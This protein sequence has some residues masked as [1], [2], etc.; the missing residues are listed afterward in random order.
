MR[1][2]AVRLCLVG[3]ALAF[4]AGRAAEP[5]WT[6]RDGEA[7]RVGRGATIVVTC[8]GD[9]NG[10]RI[11]VAGPAGPPGPGW[12]MGPVRVRVDDG[13]GDRLD[14]SAVVGADGVVAFGDDDEDRLWARLLVAE[15][16]VLLLRTTTWF[17]TVA[18]ATDGF[19]GAFA[20]LG[21]APADACPA[22]SCG[23]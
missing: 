9:A 6:V 14:A 1:L 17:A 4:G 7:R 21:C 15:R 19:Q 16:V 23:P 10:L 2:I 13:S 8:A 22:R 12:P 5:A 3:G 20:Q 11:V 18:F